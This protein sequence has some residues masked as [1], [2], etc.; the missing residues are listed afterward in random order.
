MN[1]NLHKIATS[2]I[3]S[4]EMHGRRLPLISRYKRFTETKTNQIVLK[5]IKKELLKPLDVSVSD[6]VPSLTGYN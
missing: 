1:S 4:P 6:L 2:C 5:E 3:N